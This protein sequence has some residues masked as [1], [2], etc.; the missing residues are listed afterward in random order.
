MLQTNRLD[1][2]S[3]RRRARVLTLTVLFS[4]IILMLATETAV[5]IQAKLRHGLWG[6]EQIYTIDHATGMRIPVA[7]GHFGVT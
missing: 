4:A 2:F 7:G 1:R 5:R 3:G 6:I